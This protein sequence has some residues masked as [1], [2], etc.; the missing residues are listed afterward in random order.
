MKKIEYY[1]LASVCGVPCVSISMNISHGQNTTALL[2][3]EL[4]RL[5]VQAK[6]LLLE[7]FGKTHTS[8]II[9]KLESLS[10]ELSFDSDLKNVTIFVSETVREV[11]WSVWTPPCNKVTVMDRF[12]LRPLIAAY[13]SFEAYVIVV[14]S[15]QKV[16]L[17]HA[18]DD[19][20]LHEIKA[21][22][23]PITDGLDLLSKHFT[24]SNSGEEVRVRDFYS[25]LDNGLIKIYN[26]AGMRYVIASSQLHY[27]RF[28]DTARFRSIY[29]AHIPLT[30][31]KTNHTM[32]SL[33]WEALLRLHAVEDAKRISR[34]KELI[35]QGKAITDYDEIVKAAKAGKGDLLLLSNMEMSEQDEATCL[36]VWNVIHHK[37]RVL[38]VDEEQLQTVGG[39]EIAMRL[40]L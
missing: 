29:A 4:D 33:A 35:A 18:C 24:P 32:A 9:E 27:D 14:L 8:H 19:K 34:M 36:L 12:D 2:H 20:V 28:I 3:L 13:K 31:D 16:K 40:R 21:G 5:L 6:F 1:P 15:P 30:N 37:G 7:K 25:G 10:K 23:F 11:I 39:I 38:L 22:I 26:S 17:L